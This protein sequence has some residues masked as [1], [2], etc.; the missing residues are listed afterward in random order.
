M[1]ELARARETVTALLDELQLDAWRFEV[2]PGEDP[3]GSDH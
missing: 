2:E 1:S 3:M